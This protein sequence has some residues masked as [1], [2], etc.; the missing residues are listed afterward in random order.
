[1]RVAIAGLAVL[2]GLLA[3]LVHTLRLWAEPDR[4]F[5]TDL[6]TTAATAPAGFYEVLQTARDT[7]PRDL[8][9]LVL[10]DDVALHQIS[11]YY[12]YPRRVIAVSSADPYDERTAST[13]PG[14]C[15]AA[16]GTE[17]VARARTLRERISEVAC[18]PSGCL[19]EIK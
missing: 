1:V 3:G 15:V 13:Y 9:F 14:S 12:L 10:G 6:D 11:D 8:P 7:C 17:Q 19:F 5:G 16:Y 2:V 18:A 4:A